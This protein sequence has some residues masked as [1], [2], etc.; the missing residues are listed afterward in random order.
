MTAKEFENLSG[1]EETML[2]ESFIR[3]E[4]KKYDAYFKEKYNTET[5]EV[6]RNGVPTTLNRESADLTL[7]EERS[8]DGKIKYKFM[9]RFGGIH[10]AFVAE[11]L[12]PELDKS[13][14]QRRRTQAAKREQLYSIEREQKRIE[15]LK[16]ISYKL[17]L[18]VVLIWHIDGLRSI[19]DI[20][21]SQKT[22]PE[23][24][25]KIRYLS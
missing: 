4:A 7:A 23:L 25:L 3:E 12:K 20:I 14:E 11:I 17:Q 16:L 22:L 10:E 21:K 1:W 9:E 6:L 2:V 13:D 5:I 24:Y 19:V 8:L 15:T 18:K